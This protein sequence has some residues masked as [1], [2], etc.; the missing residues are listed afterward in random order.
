MT[1]KF[2]VIDAQYVEDYK[3]RITFADGTCNVVDFEPF[4]IKCPNTYYD[5]YHDIDKFKEFRIECGN[6]V[7]GPNW[8]LI[9]NPMNLYYNDLFTDFE[10]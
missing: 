9:L 7:W 8:E 4:F 6:V 2:K 5:E 3:L 1:N 10:R